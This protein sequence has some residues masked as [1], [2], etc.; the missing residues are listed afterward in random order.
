MSCWAILGGLLVLGAAFLLLVAMVNH[1][2]QRTIDEVA[3]SL[4]GVALLLVITG[5][6]L[7]VSWWIGQGLL[8]LLGAK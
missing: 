3:W 4:A 1:F 2:L 8:H 5:T 6:A 7:G